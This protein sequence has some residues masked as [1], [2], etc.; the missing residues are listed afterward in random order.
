MVNSNANP[1]ASD[2]L[3]AFRKSRTNAGTCWVRERRA[4]GG[5]EDD[6]LF[7]STAVTV[8]TDSHQF[9]PVGLARV[10]WR[11]A[12]PVRQIFRRAFRAAGLPYFNPHSI[13]NTLVAL[14]EKLCRTAEEFKTWSQ[15]LGH[16]A[17]LTTL[18][19]IGAVQP[20]RQA[21]IVRALGRR[22]TDASSFP[23]ERIAEIVEM[24]QS[25]QPES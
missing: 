6:P 7:P 16:E 24:L 13:R 18:T 19:S 25:L 3:S 8:G 4:G 14:G 15:N 2:T 22:P 23:K 17:V 12:A 21:D 9:K 11:T 20:S 5:T 10:P 1:T